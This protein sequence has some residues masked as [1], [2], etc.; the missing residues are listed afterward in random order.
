MVKSV[1]TLLKDWWRP[2]KYFGLKEAVAEYNNTKVMEMFGE[3]IHN[4]GM[5]S[6]YRAF[7]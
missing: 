5:V 2:G 7:L 6:E 1:K 3:D 4:A